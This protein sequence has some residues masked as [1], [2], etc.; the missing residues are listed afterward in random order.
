MLSASRI[1]KIDHLVMLDS[2]FFTCTI[3]LYIPSKR[4]SMRH[5]TE[6]FMT[7]SN[8]GPWLDFWVDFKL[9]NPL[10]W[11]GKKSLVRR[12]MQKLY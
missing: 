4:L 7:H 5:V 8:Q 3:S 2:V 12:Q 1:L 10:N 11:K 9:D 6:D